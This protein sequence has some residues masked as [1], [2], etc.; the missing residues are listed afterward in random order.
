LVSGQTRIS[1]SLGST[2]VAGRSDA[3]VMA[4][5]TSVIAPYPDFC[6]GIQARHLGLA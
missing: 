3:G 5:S 4:I 6:A 1:K 2:A